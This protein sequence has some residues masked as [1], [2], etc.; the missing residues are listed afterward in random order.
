MP[1]HTNGF[2]APRVPASRHL[3]SHVVNPRPE[4][5]MCG[6]AARRVIARVH[7][8]QIIWRGGVSDLER[9]SVRPY[10]FPLNKK[11]PIAFW[12]S[13][14]SP[15]PTCVRRRDGNLAPKAI[16]VFLFHAAIIDQVSKFFQ[17]IRRVFKSD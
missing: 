7:H 10:V 8:H 16:N 4:F 15:R 17:K 5:Q 14:R 6:I 9:N 11:F 3:V 13:K 2:I 1:A 12:I